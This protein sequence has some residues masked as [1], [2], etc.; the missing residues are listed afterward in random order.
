MVRISIVSGSQRSHE[1]FLAVRGLRQERERFAR[2]LSLLLP[3]SLLPPSLLPQRQLSTEVAMLSEL[4]GGGSE[5][6]RSEGSS[7]G[8]GVFLAGEER[9]AEKFGS[10]SVLF[11]EGEGG[12]EG[13]EEEGGEGLCRWLWCPA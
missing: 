5:A 7:S 9:F 13:R 8:A 3:P 10:A 1:H 2:V 6:G 11:A 4:W 12:G